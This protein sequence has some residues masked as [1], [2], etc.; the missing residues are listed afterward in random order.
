MFTTCGSY[1]WSF[2]TQIFHSGQPSFVLLYFF[3]WSL[4][5][6]FFFDLR[7]L[8]TPLVSFVG[9]YDFLNI[10][11]AYSRFDCDIINFVNFFI[12]VI[13]LIRVKLVP[14]LERVIEK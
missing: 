7:I 10:Y 5:C 1:P 4:C 3:F 9:F 13:S 11:L 12:R 8:I 6:L 14:G 2:V